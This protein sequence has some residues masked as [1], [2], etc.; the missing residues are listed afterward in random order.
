MWYCPVHCSSPRP[1]YFVHACGVRV[2]FVEHG[3]LAFASGQF[4][5]KTIQLSVRFIHL[6]FVQF[7][8]V[9]ERCGRRKPGTRSNYFSFL[10]PDEPK[11]ISCDTRYSWLACTAVL[12]FNNI[13]SRTHNTQGHKGRQ[14]TGQQQYVTNSRSAW[15][16]ALLRTNILLIIDFC[17]RSSTDNR[18]LLRSIY[19]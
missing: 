15:P 9:S 14:H 5:P 11:G 8:L 16:P 6:R 13:N 10:F 1:F 3:V 7:F 2:V 18:V 17:N 4:A 19:W 12:V